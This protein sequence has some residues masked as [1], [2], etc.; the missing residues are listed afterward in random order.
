M[1]EFSKIVTLA[2]LFYIG[3]MAVKAQ[4]CNQCVT[5]KNNVTM[6]KN[7]ETVHLFYSFSKVRIR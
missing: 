7:N 2:L 5:H 3:S 4:T 6:N 1:K